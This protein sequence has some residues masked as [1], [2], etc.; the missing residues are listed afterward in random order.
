MGLKVMAKIQQVKYNKMHCSK[1]GEITSADLVGFNFSK[2]FVKALE[3]QSSKTWKAL[4]KLDLRF[5]Y[6]IRDLCQELYFKLN[7]DQPSTLILTVGQIIKQLEFLMKPATFGQME[8]SHRDTLL[9]NNIYETLSSNHNTPDEKMDDIEILIKMLS[10][11]KTDDIVVALPIQFI[12]SKDDFGNEIPIGIRYVIDENIYEEYERICPKC[13]EKFDQQSGYHHEFIIGLA[14]V[15]QVGKTSYLAS[16]ICQ[17]KKYSDDNCISISFEENEKDSFNKFYDN[18]ITN[19]EAGQIIDKTTIENIE[20]IPLVYVSVKINHKDFNFAFVDM[21]GEIYNND[22]DEGVDYIC[23]KRHILK[24]ADII[25][26]CIEPA[27]INSQY[28]NKKVNCTK[29]NSDDQL[30]NLVTTLNNLY[31][32]KI[33]ACIIVTQADLL[34][35]DY[36]NLFVPD[37]NI[38][39][40]YLLAE[41]ILNITKM[42]QYAKETRSFVKTKIGFEATIEDLFAGFSMFAVASYGFDVNKYELENKNIRSSMVELPFLWTLAVLGCIEAEKI[43]VNKNIFGQEKETFRKVIDRNELYI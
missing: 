33:P 26:C 35:T 4:I 29:E 15:S 14:G 32:K 27:M 40:E 7:H 34:Q 39:E 2:I 10:N 9:Y 25:W 6:T 18:I 8:N 13:G 19:F 5:Y 22:N 24:S 28:H 36:P 38:L 43:D 3:Q 31:A 12:F 23:D 21:P 1:C 30:A 11:Y 20:V 16:L 37:S 17:L 41:N 42:T